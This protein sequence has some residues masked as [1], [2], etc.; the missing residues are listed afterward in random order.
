MA[1]NRDARY[2]PR[3]PDF[4]DVVCGFA[5]RVDTGG[6]ATLSL[7]KTNYKTL[8]LTNEAVAGQDKKQLWLAQDHFYLPVRYQLTGDDGNSYEQTLTKIHVE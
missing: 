2:R 8:Q 6:G 5:A 7:A 4:A 1:P 3:C